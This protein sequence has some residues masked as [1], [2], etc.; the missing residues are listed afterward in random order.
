MTFAFLP[1]LER[2]KQS[3]F[4]GI[5]GKTFAPQIIMTSSL[6]GWTKDPATGGFCFPYL[7]S[8]SAIGQGTA[9][10]AHELIPLGIRVN[11]IAPG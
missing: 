9:T 5:S 3:G 2:W 6:N 4:T 7:F 10:L 11:G 8:K 1:L